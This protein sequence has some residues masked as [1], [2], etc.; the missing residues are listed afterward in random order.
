MTILFAIYVQLSMN[1]KSH[2]NKCGPFIA[3]TAMFVWYF[4]YLKVLNLMLTMTY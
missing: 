2:T 4:F 3:D 1:K